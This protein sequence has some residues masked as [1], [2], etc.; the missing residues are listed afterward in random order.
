MEAEHLGLY[1]LL[2]IVIIILL[3]RGE[4]MLNSKKQGIKLYTSGATMRQIGQKF[5]S[6]NQ[7]H[8]KVILHELESGKAAPLILTTQ[9]NIVDPDLAGFMATNDQHLYTSGADMRMMGQVFSST[10]QGAAVTIHSLD[11]PDF[12]PLELEGALVGR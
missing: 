3:K 10:N 2:L 8:H 11:E 9:N 1:I 4:A 6:A 5:S 7:G 12:T